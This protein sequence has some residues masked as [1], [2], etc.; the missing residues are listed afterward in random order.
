MGQLDTQQ[1]RVSLRCERP[2]RQALRDG[3]QADVTRTLKALRIASQGMEWA[4]SSV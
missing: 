1:L 3:S 4:S 2:L